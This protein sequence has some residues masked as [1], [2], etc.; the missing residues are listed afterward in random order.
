MELILCSVFTLLPDYLF[1]RYV[2]GKRFGKE[3]T[4]FTVWYELRYGI[5]SCLMATIALI[6]VVFYFHPAAVN[7]NFLFRTVTIL[8]ETVGRVDQVFVKLNDEVKAGAPLFHLDSSQQEAAVETARRKIAEVD[9]SIA[10]AQTQLA[11]ADGKIQQAQG[12]YQQAVDALATKVELQKRNPDAVA[13]RELEALRNSVDGA[14]GALAAAT[15]GKETI[16]QQISSLLPAQ[17]ASAEAALKDAQVA[18]DKTTIYAGVAGTIMQFA[19]RPGDVVAPFRPAGI[20]VPEDAGHQAVVASFSQLTAQVMKVGMVGEIACASSPLN[21]IPVV[22]TGVQDA[23]ASGQFR[24]TDQLIDVSQLKTG[25][26]TVFMESLY[27]GQVDHIPPGST[28]EAIAY[29]DNSK[30]LETEKLSTPTYIFLHVV[31][32]LALLH[33]AILRI[34]ALL[35]PAQA[36]VL[37]GH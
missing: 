10:V 19:L 35:L 16:Q 29:T 9:A 24:P 3:I 25:T 11:G 23:I 12:D 27:P 2:Q 1:R 6:T 20:L 18:L 21:V 13:E 4:F 31:D 37:N 8:P 30:R 26:I 14:K 17:K 15:A 22:V 5:T 28:C 33:A 7:V 32:T 34:Q 36:L